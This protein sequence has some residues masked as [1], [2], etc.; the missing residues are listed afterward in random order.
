MKER[1]K[2]IMLSALLQVVFTLRGQDIPAPV[3]NRLEQMA[4]ADETLIA[5]A[6]GALLQWQYYRRHPLNINTA[7]VEEWRELHVLNEHEIQQIIRYRRLLGDF[8]SVYE[9][10]A[11]P[12][13]E[14][15]KIRQ[16]LSLVNV[17]PVLV[18]PSL[19]GGQHLLVLQANRQMSFTDA[20]RKDQ[21]IYM[22]SPWRLVVRYKYMGEGGWQWGMTGEK[23]AGEQFFRGSQKKGFDFYSVH[24]FKRGRERPI[25]WALGDYTVSMGQGLVHWQGIGWG[26][27]SS[28][29]PAAKRSAILKPYTGTGESRFMRGVA[30]SWNK[31]KWETA[32]FA[33]ARMLDA[34]LS[35]DTAGF[36]SFITSGYHRTE[37]EIMNKGNLRQ[38][39]A[40]V[41]ARYQLPYVQ[42]GFNAV[43]HFYNRS[44]QKRAV[45]YNLFAQTGDRW[46]NVSVDH[47]GTFRNLH[48]FGELAIDPQGD[49]AFLQGLVISMGREMDLSFVCRKITPGYQ[50]PGGQAFTENTAVSNETGLFAGIALKPASG[51][52]L[53]C[54]TDIFRFPWLRHRI[55]APS[56]GREMFVQITHVPGKGAEHYIRFR[57][58]SAERNFPSEKGARTEISRYN[59]RCHI[60]L[61]VN[62]MLQLRQRTEITWYDPGGAEAE[63]GCSAYLEIIFRP[64]MKPWSASGRL[65]YYQTGGYNSRIYG[66]EQ[67][68]PYNYGIPAVYGNGYRWNVVTDYDLLEGIS[69]AFRCSG[70]LQ[71][72]LKDDS[73]PAPVAMAIQVRLRF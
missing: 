47:A 67:D 56:L 43:S 32:I 68:L 39:S 37:K 69:V 51:W 64:R 62:R 72:G 29:T 13:L 70:S 50:A 33:S 40:G 20:Q 12:G 49:P 36:S 14:R 16:L 3:S 22:G 53:E 18:K 26:K 15:E 34:N 24:L 27:G 48:F 73:G 54:Y 55:N 59:L 1:L 25:S 35:G 63:T 2:I 44:L 41:V 30:A 42:V 52:K 38:Y 58:H 57:G 23:D 8:I 5:E 65:Q 60:S 10:L 17:R 11:V 28:A 71:A 45:P 61:S 46:Y 7:G 9:L 6:E 4:E 66:Y 19:Q 31:G 21:T